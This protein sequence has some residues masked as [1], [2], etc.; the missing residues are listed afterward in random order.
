MEPVLGAL[1]VIYYFGIAFH[2]HGS[3]QTLDF[4]TREHREEVPE[5]EGI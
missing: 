1:C 3:Q 4:I 5:D 2:N